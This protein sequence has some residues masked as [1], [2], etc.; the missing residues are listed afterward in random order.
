MLLGIVVVEI[1]EYILNLFKKCGICYDVLN[2]KNYEC[3]VEI[4][5]GVG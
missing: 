4:V 1:F 5:V 2:V 3:E